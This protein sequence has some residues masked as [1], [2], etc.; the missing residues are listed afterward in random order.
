MNRVYLL[1]LI[2]LNLSSSCFAAQSFEEWKKDYIK[3]AS[4]RGL[5]SKLIKNSLS[6]I[7]VD[8]EVIK[9][10]KRQV[11]LSK[12]VNYQVFIKK[13]LRENPSRIEVGRE[14]LKKHRR[15]LQEIENK[16][17]VEKEIIVALWGIETF[18]GRITGDIQEDIT[19]NIYILSCGVSQ[20][21]ATV[22]T[23]SLGYY[24]IGDLAN[25]RYLVVPE[26]EVGYSFSSGYWVDIPNGPGQS[27]DFT[28]IVD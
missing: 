11:L 17:G 7:T 19:V 3:R 6:G 16:Y 15:L 5:K 25:G 8:Q 10:E 13:W 1:L 4:K 28:L 2:I 14:M 12:K 23:D 22:T 9:K 26:E 24:A 18:Y 20:P 21:H 27:Y